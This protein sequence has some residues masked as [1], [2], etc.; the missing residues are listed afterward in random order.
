M[1]DKLRSLKEVKEALAYE[2]SLTQLKSDEKL[3]NFCF[4]NCVIVKLSPSSLTPEQR[5]KYTDFLVSLT[6]EF[7]EENS[8]IKD[9]TDFKQRNDTRKIHKYLY[10]VGVTGEVLPYEP[11]TEE[12]LK[13]DKTKTSLT[14]EE[15]YELCQIQFH[16]N[17]TLSSFKRIL[18]KEY[19]SFAEYC[20][21]KGYDINKTKWEN[22]ETAIRVARQLGSIDE[23]KIR[24]KSLFKYLTDKKLF[25]ETL[26]KIQ[27]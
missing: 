9:W 16:F 21:L 7:L 22:D 10:E 8:E 6:K 19:G 12:S 17:G 11:V 4:K 14:V 13:Q 18:A 24:S 27:D 3:L 26:F 15:F 23:V 25:D 20:I 1:D 5:E 2:G